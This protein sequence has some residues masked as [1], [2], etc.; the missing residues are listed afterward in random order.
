[1]L[2]KTGSTGKAVTVVQRRL[3][4]KVDGHY[5]RETRQ[6]VRVFQ[7]NHGLDVDGIVGPLTWR[8]LFDSRPASVGEERAS[9]AVR[10][11]TDNELE[12]LNIDR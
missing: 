4:V 2:L 3:H 8:A 6:A 12:R 1:V 9:F 10:R 11:V 5:G 7:G